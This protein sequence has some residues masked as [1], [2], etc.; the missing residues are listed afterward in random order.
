MQQ[1]SFKNIWQVAGVSPR[2]KEECCEGQYGN[3]HDYGICYEK[4][5]KDREKSRQ[6][7]AAAWINMR[8]KE[9]GEN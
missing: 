9:E 4:N 7:D 3:Q 5:V 6:R 8:G 2:F 1:K